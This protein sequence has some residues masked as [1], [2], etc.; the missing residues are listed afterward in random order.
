[1]QTGP[2]D[3]GHVMRSVL[4]TRS[5]GKR[6]STTATPSMALVCSAERINHGCLEDGI[7]ADQGTEHCAERFTFAFKV[8]PRGKSTYRRLVFAHDFFIFGS[9]NSTALLDSRSKTHDAYFSN[10]ECRFYSECGF[11]L[12]SQG[13]TSL[14]GPVRSSPKSECWISQPPPPRPTP[15]LQ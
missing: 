9:K 5:R 6:D 3:H 14:A 8:L 13:G 4:C 11:S 2:L 1:M 10:S 15:L 12:L 7:L